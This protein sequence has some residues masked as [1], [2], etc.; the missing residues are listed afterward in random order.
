MFSFDLAEF[1]IC[2]T[3]ANI[4]GKSAIPLN[5]AHETSALFRFDPEEKF[6]STFYIRNERVVIAEESTNKR[7]DSI[8]DSTS[9]TCKADA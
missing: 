1:M 4:P 8:I 2:V 7:R 5:R 3:L 9:G 6:F